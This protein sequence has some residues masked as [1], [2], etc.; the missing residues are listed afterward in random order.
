[1]ALG[2]PQQDLAKPTGAMV[3]GVPLTNVRLCGGSQPRGKRRIAGNRRH[4]SRHAIG[5]V[6]ID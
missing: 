6:L 4:V 2:R 1:M 5:V 3:G